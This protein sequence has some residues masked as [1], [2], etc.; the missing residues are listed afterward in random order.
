MAGR[1]RMT[2]STVSRLDAVVRVVGRAR[3][4]AQTRPSSRSIRRLMPWHT[5]HVGSATTH[6]RKCSTA[7]RLHRRARCKAHAA[8]ALEG[9]EGTSKFVQPRTRVRHVGCS[10]R[11]PGTIR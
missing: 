4:S 9:G 8:G 7:G 2:A 10:L 11:S 3:T 6:C 1:I 5:D